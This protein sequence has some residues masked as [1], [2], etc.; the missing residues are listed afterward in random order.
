MYTVLLNSENEAHNYQSFHNK[1]LQICK[2][3]KEDDRA[4]AFA[5]ILYDFENAQISKVLQDKD[6][7]LSLNTISGKYLTVFS[8][9][10]KPTVRYKRM[11]GFGSGKRVLGYMTS[12]VQNQNPSESSN[13][14]IEKYF[15]KGVSVKYPAVLFFQVHRDEI[16]G[17]TLIQ[18]EEQE[19]EQAFIELKNYLSKAVETL[20]MISKENKGNSKEIFSLLESTVVGERTKVIAIKRIKKITNLAELASTIGGLGGK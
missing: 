5:F 4:L 15:G 7:W 9:H 19:I 6:Y 8:L 2:E 18:L 17:H 13:E 3:H 1:F 20:K 10:Y 14:L 11:K 16:I 12:I